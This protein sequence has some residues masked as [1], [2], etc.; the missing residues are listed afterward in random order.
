MWVCWLIVNPTPVTDRLRVN[1]S[2]SPNTHRPRSDADTLTLHT[3]LSHSLNTWWFSLLTRCLVCTVG[4]SCVCWPWEL[5]LGLR[6]RCVA[7]TILVRHFSWRQLRG[8]R[9]RNPRR[10]L[11]P[12]W[13]WGRP[14]TLSRTGGG[15]PRAHINVSNRKTALMTNTHTRWIYLSLHLNVSLSLNVT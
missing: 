7:E 8:I 15:P 13:T 11:L 9:D 5:T 4:Q 14:G 6:R 10:D 3:K 1:L 2:L 12:D